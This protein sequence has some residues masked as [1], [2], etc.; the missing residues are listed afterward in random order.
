MPGGKN[1]RQWYAM[2]SRLQQQGRWTHSVPQQEE[3]EPPAQRPRIEETTE[4]DDEPPP[5]ESSPTPEGK[6]TSFA[7]GFAV[8]AWVKEDS[9]FLHDLEGVARERMQREL[10]TDFSTLLSFKWTM[11]I[12]VINVNNSLYAYGINPRITASERTIKLAIGDLAN[13]VDILRGTTSASAEDLVR[14]KDC[15]KKWRVTDI[16]SDTGSGWERQEPA[17]TSTAIKRLRF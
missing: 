7:T 3:G 8:L 2:R 11:D 13:H 9:S 17:G 14:Y 10:L 1:F 12:T 5:L 6:M 15:K 16:A 4:D